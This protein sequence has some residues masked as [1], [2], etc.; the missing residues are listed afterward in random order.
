MA[1]APELLAILVCPASRAP[2]YYFPAG[3]R[4][5][6]PDDAFLFCPTSRLR[7]RVEEDVPVLLADEATELTPAEATR[8]A[9]RA[10][11]L[12]LTPT[13]SG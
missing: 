12:G 6:R 13:G 8:L 3:E 10:H 4:G 7:Y 2:L 11:E 9:A 5:D 1:L